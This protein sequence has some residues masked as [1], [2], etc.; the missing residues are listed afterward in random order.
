MHLPPC[1]LFLLL[2]YFVSYGRL[3]YCFNNAGIEGDVA[4]T[5]DM[6]TDSWDKVSTAHTP[7]TL[8]FAEQQATVVDIMLKVNIILSTC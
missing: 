1:L 7:E 4:R 8:L 5:A 2:S 6:P 3:D